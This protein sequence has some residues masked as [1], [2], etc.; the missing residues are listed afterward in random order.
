MCVFVCVCVCVCE[1][2][3]FYLSSNVFDLPI[4]SAFPN[5]FAD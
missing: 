4:F 1:H 5:I 2:V 3:P